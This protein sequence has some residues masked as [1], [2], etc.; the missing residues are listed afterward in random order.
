[1]SDS[2]SPQGYHDLD[3]LITL[4]VQGEANTPMPVHRQPDKEVFDQVMELIKLQGD[5]ILKPLADLPWVYACAAM[6]VMLTHM[7]VIVMRTGQI[8]PEEVLRIISSNCTSRLLK[9]Q[10]ILSRP[11]GSA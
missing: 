1:M 5:Q 9:M 3:R 2:E 11:Q 4:L 7:M 10:T 8:D 6:E